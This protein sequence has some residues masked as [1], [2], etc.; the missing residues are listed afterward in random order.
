MWLQLTNIWYEIQKA[1]NQ[2]PIVEHSYYTKPN[3]PNEP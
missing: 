2:Q 3:K 1:Q